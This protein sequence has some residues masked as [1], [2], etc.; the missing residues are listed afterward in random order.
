MRTQSDL[1][2]LDTYPIHQ[3]SSNAYRMLLEQVRNDLATDGCCVLKGFL[4]DFGV[5]ALRIEA[6]GVNDQ[7]HKSFNRTNPYFSKDDPSLDPDHPL[8]QFFD[9][10]NAFISADNFASDGP[11]RQVHDFAGF[12][13]FIQDCLQEKAF[14]RYADPLA[15]VIVNMADEGNGFPWHFDTNNFTVTLAIQNATGGGAF[16]YAPNIREGGENFEEVSRVLAGT[17]DKVTVLNLEPGDLQL[18]RGRYSLHRV[19]PLTGTR[20]RYVAIFS[21]VD[22]PDMVGAPER[23]KQ[24]YGKAL[25]IHYE[26]AGLRADDYLD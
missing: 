16:E 15:D 14:H 8:R 7:G 1:I 20:P 4:T 10:S 22:Q 11:L 26:R 17:S 25:P 24:L 3:A 9:R 5:E 2:N 6:D 19:A 18:F 23:A 13:G 12:D 21:Y